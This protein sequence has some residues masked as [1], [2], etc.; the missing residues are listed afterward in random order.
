MTAPVLNLQM[1]SNPM[2]T[3]S[4][5]LRLAAMRRRA[6]ASH[7]TALVWAAGLLWRDHQISHRRRHLDRRASVERAARQRL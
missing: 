6:G 7:L 1:R 5:L 2:A 4:A 3:I